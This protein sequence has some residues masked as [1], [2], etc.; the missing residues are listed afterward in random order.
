MNKITKFL[1]KELA[2]PV[3]LFFQ[4]FLYGIGIGITISIIYYFLT[5]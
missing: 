4:A 1:E 2:L 3:H 5:K